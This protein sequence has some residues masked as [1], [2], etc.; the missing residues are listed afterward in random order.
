MAR[1]AFASSARGRRAAKSGK[2]MPDSQID[3]SDIPELTDEQLRRA[4]RVGR[5]RSGHAKQLIAIRIDPA[6]SQ[7][8][9]AT[10][11]EAVQTLSDAHPRT[12]G[13][14]GE[15]K[16]RLRSIGKPLPSTYRNLDCAPQ[17]RAQAP[18]KVRY[19]IS[20]LVILQS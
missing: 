11:G 16:R 18:T 3:F 8:T 2:P 6:A 1:K 10:C 4:R 5:P 15:E 9:A 17:N 20:R 19:R 13:T 12:A 7:A 14:R